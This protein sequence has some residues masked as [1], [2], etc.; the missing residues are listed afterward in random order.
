ML[1]PT[2]M[3][4]IIKED[5]YYLDEDDN[6]IFFG[7]YFPSENPHCRTHPINSLIN[8]IK[9]CL[10]KKN[11]PHYKYKSI[12]IS[13]IGITLKRWAWS[14]YLVIPVPPSKLKN[15]PL[16]DDRLTRILDIAGIH[17]E[18][19]VELKESR[20]AAHESKSGRPTP[21]EHMKLLSINKDFI[22]NNDK[23]ILI[24]DDVITTGSQYKAIKNLILNIKP[25][26][27]VFG[28]FIARRKPY[29][30]LENVISK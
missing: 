1:N 18:E 8:N 27:Q 5:H 14:E 13:K 4:E 16:Y 29:N 23:K 22:T 7:E 11:E 30:N 15:D 20:E 19:L 25:E 26:S 3:D 17:Y 24:F 2:Q 21:D 6:C 10:S 12:A 28:F 9:K